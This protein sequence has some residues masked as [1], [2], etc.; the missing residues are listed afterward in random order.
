MSAAAVGAA[1]VSLGAAAAAAAV[2]LAAAGVES[3]RREARLLVALAAAIA[4]E[5]VLGWP[6]RALDP[7][8]A[9]RLEAL[10][11]RRA[12]GEPLSRLSGRREF[13]SLDFTLSPATLDPR[14]ES[15][16][17][18]EAALDW[19]P[20]AQ[21]LLDFGTG[22]GC[23]L[24]AFLSERPQAIGFGVDLAPAAAAAARRN[25][26]ALGLADR[27][28]FLAGHWD[29]A[30][31]TGVD[32]IFANPPY[33][34]TEAL[35]GLPATVARF[36]PRLA[37]DGGADGLQAYRALAPA[38]RRLLKPEGLGFVEIGAGQGSGVAAVFAAAGLAVQE[39]RRDLSGIERCLVLALQ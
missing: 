18:V 11:A 3:P 5:A 22:T 8:V 39:R 10:V 33:I 38:F 14:P 35:A 36:D 20:E 31:A 6:E 29:A 24:L 15:E 7:D 25:A 23:L 27:A 34:P 13:W 2:R 28:F 21:R 16:T 17:L 9:P 32:V 4:P 30:I 1:G 37:L 19:R 12:A 26:A